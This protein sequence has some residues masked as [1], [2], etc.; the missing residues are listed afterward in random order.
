MDFVQWCGVF[1][2]TL[3][4]IQEGSET[5]ASMGVRV[6]HLGAALLG[7]DWEGPTESTAINQALEDLMSAGLIEQD[8]RLPQYLKV[9]RTACELALSQ[10]GLWAEVCAQT[11]TEE[12][13]RLLRVLNRLSEQ[14]RAS[15]AYLDM[16]P[17]EA[18]YP[19]LGLEPGYE[20]EQRVDRLVR[21]L[22]TLG[23][24]RFN[25]VINRSDLGGRPTYFALVWEHRRGVTVSSAEMDALVEEG[26]T[27][28]VDVKRQLSVDTASDKAELIKDVIALANANATGGRYLLVGFT[29][30]GVYYE[31]DDTEVQALR[32]RHL[33]SLT[34][35]RLQTIVAE[36]TT[37]ALQIR[38]TKAQ[39][40]R[41]PVGK[42]EILRDASQIPYAVRKTVGSGD[43]T[44]KRARQVRAGQIFVR[45]GTVTRETRPEEIEQTN[46]DAERARRRWHP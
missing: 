44:D 40:H 27:S 33:G 30:D 14:P 39:Y 8:R 20:V 13:A 24:A 2:G 31:P 23:F 21:D 46:A 4:E 45:D 3:L 35:E 18:L 7:G 6:E 10:H 43:K 26:E 22:A 12:E 17:Y 5:A 1:L 38:Y 36:H 11:F 29:N 16:I 34:E 25:L 9:P 41:G 42:V 32:D 15:F 19:E 37:P 28:T